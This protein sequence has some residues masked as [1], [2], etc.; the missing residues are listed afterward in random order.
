VGKRP[1]ARIDRQDVDREEASVAVVLTAKWLAKDGEETRVRGFL[2]QLTGPSRAEP[3]CLY[4]Q[5][6]QDPENPRSFLI[7]E[8]YEDQDAVAAHGKT[9]H[10]ERLG[11]S[12]AIPL[13]DSRERIFYETIELE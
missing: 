1:A 13:L 9:E 11:L 2:E 6:C 12:G 8:I 4:Y 10:F 5:P 7:F 3:G